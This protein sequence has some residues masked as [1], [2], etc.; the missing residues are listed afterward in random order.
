MVNQ[1]R[2]YEKAHSEQKRKRIERY[3]EILHAVRQLATKDVIAFLLTKSVAKD[4]STADARTEGL[5]RLSLLPVLKRGVEAF[6][7]SCPAW[8][9]VGPETIDAA[10]SAAGPD[11]GTDSDEETAAIPT[12][13]KKPSQ[14]KVSAKTRKS[15]KKASSAKA[16]K[17]TA[18]K[19][20]KTGVTA[21]TSMTGKADVE[22]GV[23]RKLDLSANAPSDESIGQTKQRRVVQAKIVD[24]DGF[25]LV[26]GATHQVEQATR[27]VNKKPQNQLPTRNTS[28]SKSR[29]H[30]PQKRVLSS[31]PAADET[32]E[33]LHPSWEA[34]KK[35]QEQLKA[36]LGSGQ[37]KKIKFDE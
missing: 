8:E 19:A 34:K 27:P 1:I 22:Q 4:R 11:R 18:G 31:V 5:Q 20:A 28:S 9:D 33:K 12:R 15:K 24:S 37:A 29:S 2:R 6:Q 3:H 30:K 26:P 13:A 16:V 21:K 7:K 17:T 35:L 32:H 36:R 10:L 25:F 23:I 14:K